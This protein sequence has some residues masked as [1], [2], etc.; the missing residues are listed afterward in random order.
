MSCPWRPSP[1]Y[2]HYPM[3]KHSWCSVLKALPHRRAAFRSGFTLI[4]LLVVIAIIGTLVGLL[5]PAVQAAR[6][7]GR[8]SSCQNNLKQIGIACLAYESAKRAFPYGNALILAAATPVPKG[9]NASGNLGSGWTLE[10]MPYAENAQLKEL[11]KP[12]LNIESSDP[13]IKRLRETPVSMYA[14]PSDYPMQLAVP[15]ANWTNQYWPG[16]YRAN[17]GRSNGSVT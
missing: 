6:E 5:L 17:A 8:R 9:T 2:G 13:D 15:S 7:A 4:E 12:N 16:S 11:Y 10:I 14:C 1:E 3:K